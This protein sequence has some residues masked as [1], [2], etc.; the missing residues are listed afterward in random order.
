MPINDTTF[1]LGF[2]YVK[3]NTKHTLAHYYKHIPDTFDML[4]NRKI[5]FFY[6]DDEILNYVTKYVKTNLFKP[7]KI[8]IS[9]LPTYEISADYLQS[10]KNQDN[11]AIRL[12]NTEREK[13][14]IHYNREYIRSGEDSFRKVFT[15]WTSKL[16]LVRQII[17]FNPFET[18][19]FSWAD[20]SISRMNNY[21][22]NWNFLLNTYSDKY[23]YMYNSD[24]RY[25]GKK[26]HSCAGF[27]FG[28][29]TILLNV[30]SK[31]EKQLKTSK[32]AN[33]A[34]D[35]ETLLNLIY[36]D[37]NELFCLVESI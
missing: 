36:L 29:K 6:D 13:G 17:E 24:R 21:R 14:L 1:C 5:V 9:D 28:H 4:I 32:N 11:D 8:Q 34:H 7:I 35:E 20:V 26:I 25:Y 3:E 2:W 27:M 33:Y 16:F 15:I 23:M 31:F 12:I 18:E 22:T 37:N 30:I 10:C 19:H